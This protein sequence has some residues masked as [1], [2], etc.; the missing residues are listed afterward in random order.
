MSE[1]GFPFGDPYPH[2][3]P[4]VALLRAAYNLGGGSVYLEEYGRLCFCP[5]HGKGSQHAT[6][7]DQMW[8]AYQEGVQSMNGYVNDR[9]LTPESFLAVIAYGIRSG[10]ED[11]IWLDLTDE[12]RQFLISYSYTTYTKWVR[13]EQEDEAALAAGARKQTK[14]QFKTIANPRYP[15]LDHGDRKH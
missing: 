15:F 13:S 10:Q 5:A 7:C 12:Q 14:Y 8:A 11:P 4:L 3:T 1:F 6:G 2:D 9:R